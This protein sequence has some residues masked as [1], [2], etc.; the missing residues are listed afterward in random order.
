LLEAEEAARKARSKK[1]G[2]KK[3]KNKAITTVTW[4]QKLEIAKSELD[5]VKKD[6]VE[7]EKNSIR[8]ID[9]LKVGS[10]QLRQP[11]FGRVSALIT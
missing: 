11:A 9:T 7:T 2:G 4:E 10:V 5:Q 3:G 1:P 8:M 6:A